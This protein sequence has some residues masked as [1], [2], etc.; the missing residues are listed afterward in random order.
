M[1]Y[2]RPFRLLELAMDHVGRGP[3]WT[4]SVICAIALASST[5][6]K[7]PPLPENA[8]L[9]Y[10]QAFLLCPD[11]DITGIPR[12]IHPGIFLETDLSKETMEYIR[13]YVGKREHK[14]AIE[15]VR[16][17][18][19]VEH[20][21]WG[22]HGLL[23]AWAANRVGAYSRYIPFLMCANARVLAADGDHLAA[24]KD[25]LAVRRF[26][27]HLSDETI[28]FLG[29]PMSTDAWGLQTIQRILDNMPPD[30]Q[31]LTFLREEL[32]S[33]PLVS[34]QA[35]MGV[36]NSM[37]RDL[38]QWRTH[39]NRGFAGVREELREWASARIASQDSLPLGD[40]DVLKM[41]EEPFRAALRSVHEILAQGLSY[42]ETYVALER[43]ASHL[44]EKALAEPG[45]FG[46]LYS[47]G[48][49]EGV[50]HLFTRQLAHRSHFNAIL[51]AIE[52]YRATAA[53][54]Q[55][56][57]ALWGDLPQY[58]FSGEPFE[59]ERTAEGFVLRCRVTPKRHSQPWEFKFRVG[60]RK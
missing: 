28:V 23:M 50:P 13:Q 20:C 19:H 11:A 54:G 33:I 21:N 41:I 30:E 32:T 42:E 24:L 6:A 48:S 1:T 37:E 36:V 26:A 56:P 59:Y 38:W 47:S 53:A 34:E 3:T 55:L 15:L 9:V 7:A 60:E 14:Q 40:D 22:M 49:L 31:T 18:S 46:Y 8:A 45:G 39:P 29:C 16:I 51:A 52:I 2:R 25:C 35:W 57:D 43:V 58:P 17:A 12:E 10:Y 27:R 5:A 4:A 44:R